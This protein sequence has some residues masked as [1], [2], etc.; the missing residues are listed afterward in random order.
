MGKR[1]LSEGQ[2]L[3]VRLWVAEEGCYDDE[4]SGFRHGLR[5]QEEAQKST[6]HVVDEEGP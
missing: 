5:A 1:G 3:A 6:L 4:T 2:V